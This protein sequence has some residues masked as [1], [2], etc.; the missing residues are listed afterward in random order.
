MPGG[1][2]VKPKTTHQL[3][4]V[5]KN[6]S[7]AKMNHFLILTA[8]SHP[9]DSILHI[10]Q[11][12]CQLG[13]DIE[14]YGIDLSSLKITNN[15]QVGADVNQVSNHSSDLNKYHGYGSNI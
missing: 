15:G 2:F 12:S 11:R 13:S 3:T 8:N 6:A 14:R 9:I 7:F 5:G 1:P 10:A 4:K